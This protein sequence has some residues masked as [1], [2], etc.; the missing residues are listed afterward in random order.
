ML[1]ALFVSC[2]DKKSKID[3]FAPITNLVDSALHRKDTVAVP[4]ETGPVPTEADESFNDFIYA[5]ASDDQFQHQRTVFP[6]PY[7]NGE[8]PSKIEE[9]FWKH[10]DLFTRQP[11]YTLLFDKEED[12]D[13]VGDTSLKSVQVEWIYMKTQM[14][15]KYYFQ[16]KKG[17]WMLEAIN[18]RPIK[19]NED[20]HFV[21]FFER[22]ATDSLFQCERIRQPLV[23]VTNDP[24][25]D[26]SI[27]ETT[28]ELNNGLLSN[29]R[30][31]LTVCRISTTDK[32]TA[33]TR[34][35]RYWRSK[36]SVTDSPTCSIFSA[37]ADSGSCINLKT[38]VYNYKSIAHDKPIRKL[39]VAGTQYVWHGGERGSLHRV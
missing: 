15:K 36:E 27:L 3:P 6:L 5:Y 22:F 30:F 17:C 33:R 2:K 4:V 21:E 11:Y 26:F 28:L 18:L 35:R 38:Q 9:R 32:A 19:K 31:R 23:F 14:V 39:S 25:D 7:Y 24:D 37:G 34:L 13:I 20:E 10:D 8:V 12:M 16:R 1:L 29:R